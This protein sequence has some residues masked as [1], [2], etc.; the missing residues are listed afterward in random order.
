MKI[1]KMYAE[2]VEVPNDTTERAAAVSHT[3][4]A[5]RKTLA[6][7]GQVS[8]LA[9]SLEVSVSKC[10]IYANNNLLTIRSN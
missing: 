5:L 3:R 9:H 7:Q 8:R 6:M 1:R 2:M 10:I 4:E